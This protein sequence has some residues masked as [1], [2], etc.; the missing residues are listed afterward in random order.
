MA[1]ACRKAPKIPLCSASINLRQ[2]EPCPCSTPSPTS[3]NADEKM[4]R[5]G[6]FVDNTFLIAIDD[7]Y[8]LIRVQEGRIASVTPGPFIAPNYSFAL[9]T[10]REVWQK[11]WQRCHHSASPTCSRS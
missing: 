6:R 5:H 7:D 8:T 9:R 4:I 2:P 1:Q 3:V 10:S 11:F